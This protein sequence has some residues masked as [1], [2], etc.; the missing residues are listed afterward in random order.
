M[1]ESTHDPPHNNSD[2]ATQPRQPS[3]STLATNTIVPPI[4]TPPLSWEEA[5]SLLQTALQQY[6]QQP[7]PSHHH[8]QHNN[9]QNHHHERDKESNA[10]TAAAANTARS[11]PSHRSLLERCIRYDCDLYFGSIVLSLLLFILIVLDIENDD[12]SSH[13]LYLSETIGAA[14]LLFSSILGVWI[15]RRRRFLSQHDSEHAKRREIRKFLKALQNA[16]QP[17]SSENEDVSSSRHRHRRK[18]SSSIV[19][20]PPSSSS[21]KD[22]SAFNLTAHT[23][24]YPVYRRHTV[25]SSNSTT[26][27]NITAWSRIP[28]L[29]LVQ[30]D[31]IALQVGDIAPAHC[32]SVR[33]DGT[34][35]EI[36]QGESITMETLVVPKD[37]QTA[38]PQTID[39]GIHHHPLPLGRTTLATHGGSHGSSDHH[40]LLTLCNQMQIYVVRE[41]PIASF[42]QRSATTNTKPSLVARQI[43]RIRESLF[44][45]ALILVI[46]TAVITLARTYGNK[47]DTKEHATVLMHLPI[48]A[49]LGILPVAGPWL[50]FCFEVLGTARILTTIHP[51]AS[52]TYA[53]HDKRHGSSDRNN[54]DDNDD[55]PSQPTQS[56]TQLL[57]RY[58]QVTFLSRLSLWEVAEWL[59]RCC[60]GCQH[61]NTSPP[62]KLVRVP[63]ASIRLL[64]KLGV[65][66]A[67]SVIDDELVCEPQSI[68]QQLLIPSGKGLK[69]LDLCQVYDGD[70][71]VES[72][73]D[74]GASTRKRGKSIDS[75]SESEE[76]FQNALRRKILPRRMRRRKPRMVHS[77]RVETDDE[78]GQEEPAEREASRFDVQ[79]EEPNWWQYLPSLKCIGLACLLL[80]E[81]ND[82]KESD[83]K[84]GITATKTSSINNATSEMERARSTIA[85]L[86]CNERQSRQLRALAECIGFSTD[87]NVFGAKGDISPF[88]ERLRLHILSKQLFC[89]RLKLDTHERSSEQSRWWGLI[90]PDATSVIVKDSR[91]MAYQLLTVGDPEVVTTMCNEAW[92]GEISTILPLGSADRRNIIDTTNDWKLADLDVTAFSYSPVPHTLET[93]LLFEPGSNVSRNGSHCVLFGD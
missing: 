61:R 65:A 53:M 64:E 15:L 19:V 49:G 66:T 88:T 16:K 80:D 29:L 78:E 8:H 77:I 89:K 45:L 21:S 38:H 68:P 4:T 17:Q 92:Q 69:L 83:T 84:N 14:G 34:T 51:F 24:V 72:D 31:W 60:R 44:L 33:M 67:L 63:P 42:L 40:H 75:D 79:F 2:H 87:P 25:V 91:T 3:S 47:G 90:R 32:D 50:L 70:S 9:H 36:A 73:S 30:G 6:L 76:G 48:L 28:S 59:Q 43:G 5:R 11:Q 12:Q 13:G 20:V 1:V 56:Q 93:R 81:R 52:S 22:H 46:L 23:G 74:A 82:S 71:D 18:S 10:T 54:N 7:L 35:V 27:T 39:P 57:A 86:V 58:V 55:H 37:G 41:T 26:T 62:S 85:K